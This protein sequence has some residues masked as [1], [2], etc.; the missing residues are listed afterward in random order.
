MKL[1]V[2]RDSFTPESHRFSALKILPVHEHLYIII[3]IFRE[4]QNACYILSVSIP[5]QEVSDEKN[6]TH[7]T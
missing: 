5:F 4:P 2:K 1:S 6:P 7:F 3:G